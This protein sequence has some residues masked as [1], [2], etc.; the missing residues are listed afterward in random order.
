MINKALMR[1]VFYYCKTSYKAVR[2]GGYCVMGRLVHTSLGSS[3][4]IARA[5]ACV[6]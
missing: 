6:D 1:C 3:Y 4:L 5:E 2:V